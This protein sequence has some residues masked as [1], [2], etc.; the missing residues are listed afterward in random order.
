MFCAFLMIRF[1]CLIK[2][3]SM[4][5][6]GHFGINL[7]GFKHFQEEYAIGGFLKARTIRC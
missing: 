1:K 5:E 4:H 2:S 7:Q 3:K 6:V